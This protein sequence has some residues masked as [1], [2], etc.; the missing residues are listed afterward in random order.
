MAVSVG[1]FGPQ[2]RAPP[3]Y[4]LDKIRSILLNHGDF[5]CI[6]EEISSLND[7]LAMLSRENADIGRLAQGRRYTDFLIDWVVNGSAEAVASTSSGIVALPRLVLVQMAQYLEFLNSE[8]LT[9]A[10]FVEQVRARRGGVQGY[11]G[12]LP[13]ALAVACARS[14][15]ELV[16]LTCT[17]M[18]L[19]FAIGLC[20]ELGD[21][22]SIP[23]TTTLVVR[24]KRPGQAE[25]LVQLFPRV[26]LQ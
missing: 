11:C 7:V 8:G 24:L 23:G 18:R 12:G 13:A 1:V 19:A 3:P 9:H 10:A 21:C 6:R 20:A 4:Y 14:E 15:K 5:I 2:S 25:E 26:S 22:S 16:K 17:A